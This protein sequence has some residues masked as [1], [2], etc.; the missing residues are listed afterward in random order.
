MITRAAILCV[1]NLVHRSVRKDRQVVAKTY[2][3][4]FLPQRRSGR[5][6]NAATPRAPEPPWFCISSQIHQL[7]NQLITFPA[8]Q[9]L[10]ITY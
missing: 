10:I 6:G 5:S 3:T 9:L 4:Y 1:E 7:S 8:V 2:F